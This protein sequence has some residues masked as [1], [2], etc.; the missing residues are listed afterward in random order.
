MPSRL[1]ALVLALLCALA[2]VLPARAAHAQAAATAGTADDEDDATKNLPFR[3]SMLFFE[4]SLGMNTFSKSSQLSYDPYYAMAF[5]LWLYWHFGERS[6]L[7]LTQ[8]IEVE[9]TDSNSTTSRQKPLLGDTGLR[10][11]QKLVIHELTPARKLTFSGAIDASAPTSLASQAAGMILGVGPRA[12]VALSLEDALH[13]LSLALSTGYMRRFASNNTV[14]ADV[15][16]PCFSSSGNAE[17]TYLGSLSSPRDLFDVSLISNLEITDKLGALL[18]LTFDFYHSY[19]LAPAEITTD[20]GATLALPD[21][22]ATHF[23][24]S[25]TL[26]I[27]VSYQVVPML[28]MLLSVTSVFSERSPNGNLR[29]PLRPVDTV[30]GLTATLMLDQVY[31]SAAGVPRHA[32]ATTAGA[33]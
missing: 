10:F 33:R 32:T 6:A 17:C 28:D 18:W 19:A 3:D 27:G 21:A 11:S 13:G 25:R 15:P 1:V 24:N 4:Q 12:V 23:H 9:L 31:V 30:L 16:Y 8:G 5:D 26:R 7:R 20:T 29:A 22:S 2:C 14:R